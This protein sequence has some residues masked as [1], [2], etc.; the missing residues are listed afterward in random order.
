MATETAP[1]FLAYLN[2]E[3][4]N[5]LEADTIEREVG[6]TGKLSEDDERAGFAVLWCFLMFKLAATIADDDE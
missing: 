5:I 6:V 3:P 2:G 1:L 4:V